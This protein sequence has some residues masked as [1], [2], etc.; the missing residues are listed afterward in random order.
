MVDTRSEELQAMVAKAVEI[1][2]S[3]SQGG[4]ADA[5]LEEAQALL[6]QISSFPEGAP[7]NIAARALDL[8]MT[9]T[10]T[11]TKHGR[12]QRIMQ[13]ILVLCCCR[14]IDPSDVDALRR[15][16]AA[17]FGRDIQSEGLMSKLLNSRWQLFERNMPAGSEDN[18]CRKKKRRPS[19]RHKNVGGGDGHEP[20]VLKVVADNLQPNLPRQG[21]QSPTP[22][23]GRDELSE[24]GAPW[25]RFPV[26]VHNTFLEVDSLSNKSRSRSCAAA[27]SPGGWPSMSAQNAGSSPE[28]ISNVLLKLQCKNT[29][30]E[31]GSSRDAVTAFLTESFES[32][33]K[34]LSWTFSDSEASHS[35]CDAADMSRD[36]ALLVDIALRS[37]MV[38]QQL[39]DSCMHENVILGAEQ[40][41]QSS[42]QENY[43]K[44]HRMTQQLI[45]LGLLLGIKD[46]LPTL[47]RALDAGL[48]SS[49]FDEDLI[50]CTCRAIIELKALGLLDQND[51]TNVLEHITDRDFKPVNMY[52]ISAYVGVLGTL[53]TPRMKPSLLERM[54][55]DVVSYGSNYLTKYNSDGLVY[56]AVWALNQLFKNA[57][58]H[59]SSEWADQ[60][61]E[62]AVKVKNDEYLSSCRD[63]WED[64]CPDAINALTEAEKLELH[65]RPLRCKPNA[66]EV[67]GS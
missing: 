23:F 39:A 5:L 40:W 7:N 46:I 65:L 41:L 27:S 67:T 17:A 63:G 2:L 3:S 38:S 59:V 1:I 30:N 9:A 20:C 31:I 54:L 34:A 8:V 19:K 48:Q 44:R 29:L 43:E 24:C 52:C 28:S 14:D 12:L 6:F 11:D 37:Q 15:S 35:A 55:G 51:A 47:F 25:P 64:Q 53:C 56:E 50:A 45:F 61:S 42:L 32:L 26:K 4:Q 66:P 16:L 60:C 62:F 49:T 58:S 33:R 10:K 36:R 13:D 21:L 57:G 22:D 18:C